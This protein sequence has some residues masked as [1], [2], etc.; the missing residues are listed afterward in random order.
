MSRF[1]YHKSADIPAKS[2][3]KPRILFTQ[4]A[5]AYFLASSN[6]SRTNNA[7]I[8]QKL[9]LKDGEPGSRPLMLMI[10]RQSMSWEES[11]GPSKTKY[12]TRSTSTIIG[13]RVKLMILSCSP[14]LK[15]ISMSCTSQYLFTCLPCTPHKCIRRHTCLPCLSILRMMKIMSLISI[16]TIWCIRIKLG[17][18]QKSPLKW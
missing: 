14:L 10:M 15:K 8:S 1:T 17:K 7:I 2:T 12:H 9:K 4:E 11:W 3:R 5:K 13:C 16:P 6:S 18:N